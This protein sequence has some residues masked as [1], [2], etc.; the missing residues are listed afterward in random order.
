MLDRKFYV[1]YMTSG[2]DILELEKII[3]SIETALASKGI[4]AYVNLVKDKHTG[5]LEVI[6]EKIETNFQKISAMD[7]L[8]V[9]I[10]NS[11]KS[12]EQL[13][14]VGYALALKKPVVV[15]MHKDAVSIINHLTN[16][17]IT[18]NDLSDLT[19]KIK[20]LDI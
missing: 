8:F 17:V 3:R 4:K 15:A 20:E 9:L 1:S 11:E 5:N 2:E 13:V 16:K 6:G 18:Y 7:G 12:E 14:N 10:L 19:N